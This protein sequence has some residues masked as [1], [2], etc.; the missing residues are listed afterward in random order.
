MQQRVV[1]A[2]RRR[3]GSVAG[4]GAQRNSRSVSGVLGVAGSR[5]RRHSSRTDKICMIRNLKRTLLLILGVLCLVLAVVGAA[6]P[7]LQGWFFLI[8]GILLISICV[9]QVRTYMEQHTRKYPK[10]H[11]MV[12]RIDRWLRSNI[13]EV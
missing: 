12:E 8:L 2:D 1:T 11:A 9:P 4:R 13:G 7:F 5:D 3:G 10:L 6:L